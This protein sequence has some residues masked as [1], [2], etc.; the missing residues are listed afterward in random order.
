MEESHRAGNNFAAAVVENQENEWNLEPWGNTA[1]R[2]ED[3]E[4]R[5]RWVDHQ[6]RAMGE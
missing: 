2:V 5:A 1:G 6:R 3:G 4:G